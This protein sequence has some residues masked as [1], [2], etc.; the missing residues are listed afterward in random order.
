[1]KC[2]KIE[3]LLSLYLEDE[4]SPEEKR[5]VEMHLKTCQSCFE[6][7]ALIEGTKESLTDFPQL[8]LSK[9]RLDR[10]YSVPIRKKRL[11]LS[12]DFLLR[13]SF[14][15]I[16][17]AVTILLII[18]SFYL[19]NPDKNYINRSIDRQAHLGYSKIQ[20]LYAKAESFTDNLG[21]Y[22]DDIL[23][24]IKNINLFGESED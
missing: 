14:Q 3:E 2:E 12:F 23:V 4:L 21:A 6:L 16:M 10:L 8:E 17:A 15:P 9:N 20:K 5:A 13:P 19:F 22:K 1:M 24:S 7:L 18:I 11:K